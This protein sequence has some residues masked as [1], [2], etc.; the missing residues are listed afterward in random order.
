MSRK[1]GVYR[2]VKKTY[3]LSEEDGRTRGGKR[4]A[5][6]ECKHAVIIQHYETPERT[7]CALCTR[8][9]DL[10]EKLK[11]SAQTVQR[12]FDAAVEQRIQT[13]VEA[14][15]QAALEKLTAPV[16]IDVDTR[17]RFTELGDSIPEKD[18]DSE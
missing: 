9:R 5:I 12:Q 6:L 13:M 17:G 16:K 18:D 14:G 1:S 15:I 4:A 8:Q 7:F 11:K 10:T 3:V 2:E